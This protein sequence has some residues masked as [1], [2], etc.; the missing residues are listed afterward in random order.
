VFGL[1]LAGLGYSTTRYCYYYYREVSYDFTVYLNPFWGVSKLKCFTENDFV[2]GCRLTVP[3][4]RCSV[5]PGGFQ[6][7]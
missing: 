5:C 1:E 7:R 3:Q 2:C 6:A 4:T